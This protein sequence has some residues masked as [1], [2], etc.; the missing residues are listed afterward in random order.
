VRN[1]FWP[2]IFQNNDLEFVKKDYGTLLIK[3]LHGF[4]S[5]P[6]FVNLLRSSEIDSWAP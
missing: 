4:G 6:V 1:F 2:E 5:E 3:N